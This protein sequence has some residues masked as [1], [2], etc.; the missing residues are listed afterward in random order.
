MKGTKEGVHDGAN[1]SAKKN[2]QFV[3]LSLVVLYGAYVVLPLG[4]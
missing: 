3:F 4:Q 2:M 1:A